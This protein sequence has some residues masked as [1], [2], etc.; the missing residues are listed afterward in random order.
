MRPVGRAGFDVEAERI[1]MSRSTW[2]PRKMPNVLDETMRED[3][4]KQAE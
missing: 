3:F 2:T 1:E 4:D